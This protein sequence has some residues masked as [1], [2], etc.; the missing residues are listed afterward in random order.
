MLHRRPTAIAAL[1]LAL[2]GSLSA[3][4]FDYP[5]DRVNTIAAGTDNRDASVD[6]LGARVLS[7]AEGE[8]RVIGALANNSVDEAATLDAVTDL[9][10]AITVE[11]FEP[12]EV[13]AGRGVNLSE[14]E[15]AIPLTGDFVAGDVLNLEF[16][17]STGETV[18]LEV[19]VVKNCWQY[20]AVPTP[21]APAE[22]GSEGAG[23]AEG[24]EAFEEPTAELTD[25][26]ES[27]HGEDEG[28]SHIYDCEAPEIEG[29]H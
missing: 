27:G 3:C 26:A 9:D 10:G 29:G 6:V 19:P 11:E 16:S 18:A 8:G 4:G 21:S 17:F 7:S 2:A 22:R 15:T 28:G 24:G 12:I 23:A 25:G 14:A 5:T 20:T 1:L 13:A